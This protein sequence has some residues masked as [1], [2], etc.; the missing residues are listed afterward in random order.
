VYAVTGR[1]ASP[2]KVKTTARIRPPSD[3]ESFS[4]FFFVTGLDLDQH[5]MRVKN[6]LLRFVRSDI[7]E[8]EMVTIGIV[9]SRIP[10]VASPMV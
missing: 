7:V 8:G 9:L 3:A 5:G 10:K 1:M 4:T 6:G 2:R